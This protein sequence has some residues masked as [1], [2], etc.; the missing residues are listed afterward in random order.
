MDRSIS[1]SIEYFKIAHTFLPKH[2][3]C[4]QYTIPGLIRF[5]PCKMPI[6]VIIP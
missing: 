1:G 2:E 6:N 5:G 4:I 3:N